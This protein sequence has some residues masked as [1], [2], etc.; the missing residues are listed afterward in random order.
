MTH[1]AIVTN[2][3]IKIYDASTDVLSPVFNLTLAE[4]GV[5]CLTMKVERQMIGGAEVEFVRVFV[6]SDTGKIFTHLLNVRDTNAD[7]DNLVLVEEV[8]VEVDTRD[9]NINQSAVISIYFAPVGGLL[10]V[11]FTDSPAIFGRFVVD[12]ARH[13]LV[14]VSVVD[15]KQLKGPLAQFWDSNFGPATRFMELGLNK[16][17]KRSVF[18]S[19]W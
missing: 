4:A 18:V 19:T 3:F 7:S 14:N 1:L 9:H 6:G 15:N 16:S 12:G 2:N 10:F 8:E 17:S 5:N 11:G 13:K